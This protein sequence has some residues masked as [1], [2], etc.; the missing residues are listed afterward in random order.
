[1]GATS[2]RKKK[3]T[4]SLTTAAKSVR[5]STVKGVF[6]NI[7]NTRLP[8]FMVSGALACNWLSTPVFHFFR[9]STL[10]AL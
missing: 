9:S 7:S 3:S 2:S 8:I 1:V 10:C 5:S 4:L 6:W